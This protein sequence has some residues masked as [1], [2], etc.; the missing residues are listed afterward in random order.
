[1]SYQPGNQ[2]GNWIVRGKLGA[3]AMGI[4]Y[5]V[6]HRVTKKAAA[7]KVLK[8]GGN[9]AHVMASKLIEEAKLLARL[10]HDNLVE[11]YDAGDGSDEHGYWIAMEKLSGRDLGELLT[12]E[13]PLDV[14]RALGIAAQ[15]AAGAACAHGAG[16]VHRDLKPDNVHVSE[17]GEVKVIDF[18]AGQFTMGATLNIP[19]GTIPYMSPEQLKN[20][21][22]L[23]GRSD[24][25]ALGHILYA[26]LIGKHIYQQSEGNW[27]PRGQVFNNI[28]SAEPLSTFDNIDPRVRPLLLRALQK[29]RDKRYPSMG[30]FA[31]DMQAL[32]RSIAP[33]Y[34][35]RERL[36]D[37]ALTSASVSVPNA[38][39]QTDPRTTGAAAV[40][41]KSTALET[42][43]QR[44]PIRGD[45]AVLVALFTLAVGMGIVLLVTAPNEP[46]GPAQVSSATTTTTAT[47]VNTDDA[48]TATVSAP[49]PQS[50]PGSAAA[51][52][53][54]ITPPIT[55]T[56]PPAVAPPM[57]ARAP[58]PPRPS[59]PRPVFTRRLPPPPPP[60]R[61][62]IDW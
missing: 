27:L 61:N 40:V 47:S 43:P 45:V 22:D 16:V 12:E 29:D 14:A 57:T 50:V 36:S 21:S 51:P 26:M 25:Y 54:V 42:R 49:T 37:A 34:H 18:G 52:P 4:V 62:P 53:S 9:N 32:R 19:L 39:F 30:A 10:E 60:P 24:V 33:T 28:L 3:G 56:P 35:H 23:D 48:P 2:I 17:K 20:A 55:A 41:A 11:V 8:L 38:N 13:G 1:M 7:L 59:S 15:I 46:A 31:A 6:E 5:E 58:A 44:K